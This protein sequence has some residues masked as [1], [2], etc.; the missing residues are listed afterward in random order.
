[1]LF[2]A[3]L[4][5]YL[6][7]QAFQTHRHLASVNQ[8]LGYAQARQ[9]RKIPM[10]EKNAKKGIFV[11]SKDDEPFT[12]ENFSEICE[13]VREHIL[14]IGQRPKQITLREKNSDLYLI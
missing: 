5:L 1:M 3:V 9:I 4:N 8:E 2:P 13:K 14:K 6:A 10:V 7:H 11:F 12:R